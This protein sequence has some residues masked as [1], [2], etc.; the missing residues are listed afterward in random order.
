MNTRWAKHKSDFAC[1]LA[2]GVSESDDGL[3]LELTRAGG[4]DDRQ[5]TLIR[6]TANVHTDG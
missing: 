2:R 4:S 5:E 3:E 6:N 1:S